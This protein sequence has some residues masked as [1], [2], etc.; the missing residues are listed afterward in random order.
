MKCAEAHV[1]SIAFE[2]DNQTPMRVDGY[3]QRNLA[4]LHLH[5]LTLTFVTVWVSQGRLALL[6]K[7]LDTPPGI[8]YIKHPHVEKLRLRRHRDDNVIAV[9][10]ADW[11]R[12]YRNHFQR[13]N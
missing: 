12:A 3:R 13:F 5:G 7:G 1:S 9:F 4:T 6:A 10:E 8:L 2:V 11:M